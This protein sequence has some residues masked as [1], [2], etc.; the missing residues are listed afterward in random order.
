MFREVDLTVAQAQKLMANI[1]EEKAQPTLKKLA[2]G[3]QIPKSELHGTGNAKDFGLQVIG[4]VNRRLRNITGAPN[5]NLF[6]YDSTTKKIY[7][8]EKTAQ[9]LRVVFELPEPLPLTGFYKRVGD[10]EVSETEVE[11]VLLGRLE[12]AWSG[13]SLR[14]GEVSPRVWFESVHSQLAKSGLQ[15]IGSS[16]HDYVEATGALKVS[17]SHLTEPVEKLYEFCQKYEIDTF[18]YAFDANSPVVA[19]INT[20]V[21]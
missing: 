2:T 1:N 18:Y 11:P 12:Q 10:D 19:R 5:A 17:L 15:L 16:F 20:N 13:F 21:D 3:K 7:V 8:S 4:A 9:S 14:P 6:Q